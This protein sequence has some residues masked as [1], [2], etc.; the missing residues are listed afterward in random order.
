MQKKITTMPTFMTTTVGC[1]N[2]QQ[3]SANHVAQIKCY[4]LGIITLSLSSGKQTNNNQP[5][6][7]AALKITFTALY[8]KMHN[9]GD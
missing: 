9:R 7:K 5:P 6:N 8:N 4:F 2:N 3:Q 1:N